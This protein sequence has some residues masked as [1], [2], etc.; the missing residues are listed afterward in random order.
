MGETRQQMRMMM[1]VASI[2]GGFHH[3]SDLG[4]RISYLKSAVLPLNALALLRLQPFLLPQSTPTRNYSSLGIT[5][6]LTHL[7]RCSYSYRPSEHGRSDFDCSYLA[8]NSDLAQE[9]MYKED[10]KIKSL[11]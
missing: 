5:W 7:V 8:Q 6:L 3:T 1:D 11:R 10:Q 9:I 2:L 4:S